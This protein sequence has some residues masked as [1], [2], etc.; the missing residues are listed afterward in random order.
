MSQPQRARVGDQRT[1]QAP[2]LRPM[3]D[4][5]D[6]VVG[7]ADRDEFDQPSSLADDPQRTVAGPDQGDRGLDDLREHRLE[8]EGGTDGDDRF[9]ERVD[10][11]PGGQHGL[12]PGLKLAE[13]IIQ[14]RLRRHRMRTCRLHQ[15]PPG[16]TLARHTLS[17]G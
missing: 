17:N 15:P 10:P 1:E 11:V 6:L 14:A 2:A 7:Q 5:L 9:Q 8:V 13:Q 12:Q 16:L 4:G 3:M